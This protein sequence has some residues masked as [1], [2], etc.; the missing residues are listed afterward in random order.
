MLEVELSLLADSGIRVERGLNAVTEAGSIHGRG[1]YF[2]SAYL[3]SDGGA[4]FTAGAVWA[5]GSGSS[6]TWER[7]K[8]HARLQ[9]CRMRDWRGRGE[10]EGRLH[11]DVFSILRPLRLCVR[12]VA[13]EEDCPSASKSYVDQNEAL[14]LARLVSAGL[15]TTWIVRD[16]TLLQPSTARNSTLVRKIAASLLKSMRARVRIWAQVR[17]ESFIGDVHLPPPC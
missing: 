11:A 16:N 12:L 3:C 7:P 10:C 8:L 1:Y 14:S 2:A 15:S 6:G 4:L 13:G 17:L 5:V 9:R